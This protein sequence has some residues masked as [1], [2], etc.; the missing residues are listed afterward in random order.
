MI[1]FKFCLLI[2]VSV[3][4]YALDETALPKKGNVKPTA[5]FESYKRFNTMSYKKKRLQPPI[6]ISASN[7]Q[8]YFS[9][10][11]FLSYAPFIPSNIFNIA[12]HLS[13]HY[14]HSRKRFH[15][16][17][18]MQTS[19]QAYISRNVN[20]EENALVM[21][22]WLIKLG[23]DARVVIGTLKNK[24]HAWVMMKNMQDFFI[25]DATLKGKRKH[26]P[27]AATLPNYHPKYMYNHQYTWENQGSSFTTRYDSDNW[28]KKYN[29]I[30]DK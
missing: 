26:Y 15:K 5:F 21:T 13:K 22:D 12:S 19:K 28:V 24:P 3:N 1:G 11:L 7:K 10:G 20:N 18:F 17:R 2:I 25:L 29:F 16:L 23:Y 27:L 30:V 14:T 8:L 6:V 4:L 9:N